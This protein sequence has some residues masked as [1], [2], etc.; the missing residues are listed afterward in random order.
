TY[1]CLTVIARASRRFEGDPGM[2]RLFGLF[3]LLTALQ[4]LVS[5]CGSGAS[6][7]PAERKPEDGEPEANIIPWPEGTKTTG[8]VQVIKLNGLTDVNVAG[9]L[10]R[11]RE[12]L[13]AQADD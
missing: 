5:G 10:T 13:A 8:G 12:E 7:Q 11:S 1:T 4:V 2:R 3:M 6:E 9:L